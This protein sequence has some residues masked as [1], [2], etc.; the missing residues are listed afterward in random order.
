MKPVG[1]YIVI[2]QIKEEIST[3][4]GILLTTEDTKDLRY[5]KGVVVMPGTDVVVVKPMDEVYYDSRAGYK[6]V[7]NGTQHTVISESDVV[8]VL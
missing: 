2:D 6:M 4:S 7:I 1:K 5:K 3:A 8:V